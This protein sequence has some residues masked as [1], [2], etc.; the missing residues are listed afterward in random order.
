MTKRKQERLAVPLVILVAIFVLAGLVYWRTTEV[1][2]HAAWEELV[3]STPEELTEA[4]AAIEDAKTA[5]DQATEAGANVEDAEL[6]SL[7]ISEVENLENQLSESLSY[8]S[9]RVTADMSNGFMA[10]PLGL[11]RHIDEVEIDVEVPGDFREQLSSFEKVRA[12]LDFAV[13]DLRS[14]TS[15]LL[16]SVEDSVREAEKEWSAAKDALKAAI[17]S[18]KETAGTSV[19]EVLDD[20]TLTALSTEITS[21]EKLLK[22]AVKAP[23]KLSD[24]KKQTKAMNDTVAKLGNA[25]KAVTDSVE[26]LRIELEAALLVAEA[27]VPQ[28]VPE[29]V[30]PVEPAPTDT[31]TSTNQAEGGETSNNVG[32]NEGDGTFEQVAPSPPSPDP[33]EETPN[34]TE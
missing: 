28:W 33:D 25:Q 20:A 22:E 15:T 31:E 12:R 13:E 26:A 4:Q 23:K 9:T 5:Q 16:T 10:D 11:S 7:K 2:A 30:V 6:L 27:E 8:A 1:H 19:G 18:A 29:P 34:R 14:N 32:N 21:A 3:R 17:V 24:T